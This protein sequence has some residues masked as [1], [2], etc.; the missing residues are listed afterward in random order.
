[1]PGWKLF[2][3]ETCFTLTTRHWGWPRV[4]VPEL[5][6][7]PTELKYTPFRKLLVIVGFKSE[8]ARL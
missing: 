8:R 3:G 4:G 5:P 7:K 1:M 2:T 6:V